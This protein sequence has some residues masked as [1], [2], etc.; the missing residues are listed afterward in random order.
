MAT[1]AA[2]LPVAAAVVAGMVLATGA[3]IVASPLFPISVARRAEL[4]TG[5]RVEPFVLFGGAAALTVALLGVVAVLA[6]RPVRPTRSSPTAAGRWSRFTRA[7]P[8]ATAIGC[9]SVVPAPGGRPATVRSGMAIAGIAVG[10][11]GAVAVAVFL[12]SQR[13]T[14]T[15]PDRYGWTWDASPD[16]YAGEVDP[17]TVVRAMSE[18]DRLDAVGGLF[19]NEG[20]VED[21]RATSCAFVAASGRVAPRVV[22]GRAPS[23]AG[24]VALLQSTAAELGVGIG[25]RVEIAGSSETQSLVVIGTVLLPGNV[26]EDLGQGAVVTADDLERLTGRPVVESDER[27]LLLTYAD[28]VDVAAFEAELEAQYPVDFSAYS[29]PQPPD[30]ITQLDRLRPVLTA[31]AAFLG[32][33]GLIALVH[34]LALSARERRGDIGVLKALGFVRGQVRSIVRGQGMTV[35]V[36]GL[37]VGLPVGILTGRSAWLVTVDQLEIVDTPVSPVATA[38]AIVAVAVCGA[39][40][41][42]TAIGWWAARAGPAEALRTE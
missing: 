17:N 9:A 29:L 37:I 28:G 12:G 6:W 8:P 39:A 34:F 20:L 41:V 40:A 27:R 33:L 23:A 26:F 30:L 5:V 22:D 35:A 1:A 31:L 19:C 4:A 14:I 36:I 10:V 38:A 15:S 2:G 11:A 32:A 42:S 24:E 3:A 25:D 13:H 16:L 7:L 18:H 21:R